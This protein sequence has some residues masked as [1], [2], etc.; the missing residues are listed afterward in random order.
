MPKLSISIPHA[1]GREAAG[2][3]L[4]GFMERLKEEHKDK[5]GNLQEEWSENSLKYSFTTF[6]FKISGV[7][8]VEESEVKMDIDLPFAAMMFKGKIE[9]EIRETLARVLRTR[10]KKENDSGGAKAE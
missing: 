1:L 7:G 4:K 5:V 3:R 2:Q 9:S 10:D 8:T 6:G